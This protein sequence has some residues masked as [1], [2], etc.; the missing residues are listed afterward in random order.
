MTASPF[1]SP[2]TV[3]TSFDPEDDFRPVILAPT[4]NNGGTLLDVLASFE[5]LGL[6]VI[7]VNDGATDDTADLL[8]SWSSA[9]TDTRMVVSHRR[10]RGKGAA[11]KTG[12]RSAK[13]S[14]F[15]H[16]VTMDTD[17]QLTPTDVPRMLELAASNRDALIVGSRRADIAGLPRSNLIGWYTTALGIWLETGLLIPDNQCG[18]RVYPLH[19]F[20]AVRCLANR[21]ALEGEVLVRAA[22]AGC[23]IIQVP[24]ACRYFSDEER[25]S[26]FKAW[27][28]GIRAFLFH[29]GL[30]IRRLMPIPHP[31]LSTRIGRLKTP[32]AQRAHLRRWLDP[33]W[34]FQQLR[35]SRLHQLFLAASFGIG[36]F[37]ANM[38]LPGLQPLLA[39]L[40]S[41]RL[42]I[43]LYPTLFASLLAFTRA[44][45]WLVD[46][47]VGLGNVVL[48]LEWIKP[49]GDLALHG[50]D[51]WL[52]YSEYAAPWLLGGVVTGFL[53]NWITIGSLVLL[54]RLV[55]VRGMASGL[56]SSSAD[57]G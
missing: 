10:N 39:A 38:P 46:T 4:Y 11:L 49:D 55:P 20:E 53:C 3:P 8:A 43:S 26:H 13:Q 56:D 31:R 14:G 45:R 32:Q 12:F 2:S 1:R 9:A 30:T 28:D 42:N 18:L 25:V 22:W 48:R 54:F 36:T 37:M 17:G 47:A 51:G 15:T 40:A 24:V 19:L 50:L 21:F 29:A 41:K 6:P 44:G 33:R 16:A 27:R 7:V 5:P 23:P 52:F 34:P 35:V 57:G